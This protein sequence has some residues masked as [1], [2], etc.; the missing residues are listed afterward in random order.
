M[1]EAIP[2]LRFFLYFLVGGTVVT[3]ISFLASIGK[4]Q[5]AAFIGLIPSNT[6]LTFI[7]THREGGAKTTTEYA[8]TMMWFTPAWLLYVATV[9]WLL[10]KQG[11]YRSLG[12]GLAVFFAAS[13]LT[14]LL[15]QWMIVRA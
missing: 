4:P 7:F 6:I 9:M 15:R 12:A 2:G 3:L 10:P 14:S 5:L 1:L 8:R 11:L 13:F